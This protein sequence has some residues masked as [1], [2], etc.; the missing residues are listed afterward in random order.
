MAA[1]PRTSATSDA[2]SNRQPP[3][4]VTFYSFKGG[5]GRTQALYNVGARLAAL[6]RKVLMV[7]VDLEAP[8][9]SI[10]I[11]KDNEQNRKDGFAE[12]AADLIADLEAALGEEADFFA[13]LFEEYGARMERALHP[14]EAPI[15]PKR[16]ELIERLKPHF[17]YVEAQ[18]ALA[19]LTTG[20]IDP[21]D[22][23]MVRVPL[24]EAFE[25][26][27]KP[28]EQANAATFL[29]MPGEAPAP[30]VL[31]NLGQVFT[32]VFR[33]L[34]RTVPVPGFD[35]PFDY[36]LLDSRSGLADVGGLCLRGLADTR[37]VLTGLNRQ[38]LHGTRLVLNT[39]PKSERAPERLLIVFSPVPEGE[40]TLL[41][42][43]LQE[44]ASFL[45]V[46][47]EDTLRLHYHPRI[48]LEEEAFVKPVH[49]L[50]RIYYEYEELKDHVLK[51]SGRDPQ[52]LINAALRRY[53]EASEET[54][55]RQARL[56]RSLVEVAVVDPGRVLT[57]LVG[58]CTQL[59]QASAVD[60]KMVDLFRLLTVLDHENIEALGTSASYFGQVASQQWDTNA[61]DVVSLFEG[62]FAYY[63]KI[64][65]IQPDEDRA[66]NN[67]G[68]SLG[69]LAR[70]LWDAG[71][72]EQGRERYEASFEKYARAVEIKPDKHEAWNNWGNA[73]GEL[74]QRA[75]GEEEDRFFD[76]AREKV[77][78]AEDIKEG[79]GAYNLACLSAL[80]GEDE[81][82][83]R[84]LEKARAQGTLP[85]RTHLLQDADLDGVRD[86]PWFQEFLGEESE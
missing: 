46:E 36:V 35:E 63:K 69:N 6:R 9:L 83:Q 42:E 82:A 43:R 49:R 78:T 15:P 39:L 24:A 67:W 52:T 16:Q 54:E 56:V 41:E 1:E 60:P 71:E 70:R 21:T 58:I 22:A 34:L 29:A 47:E 12:I 80:H 51:R 23:R 25:R 84:W 4:L 59:S 74:A 32:L 53:G 79:S 62:A 27:L 7:D 31:H 44:A 17:P 76:E 45:E 64:L 2:R 50:A 68:T 33:E 85:N 65:Q 10:G 61:G 5:V 86:K 38:N 18:G 75:S 77:L 3:I 30:E 14:L 37:V 48:A 13:D 11:L 20:R 19:L 40:I 57:L 26:A 8:G 72:A 66:W 55:E 81:E 28:E 73:L